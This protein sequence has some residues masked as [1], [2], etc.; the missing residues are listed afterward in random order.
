MEQ[1]K[2]LKT[3]YKFSTISLLLKFDEDEIRNCLNAIEIRNKIVHEGL[4]VKA[5]H[6]E[7]L[8]FLFQ[9][10]SK[11]IHLNGGIYQNFQE[12]I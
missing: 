7:N 4:M 12:L 9:T 1:F 8:N 10:I 2:Q 6:K 11:I 3:K 5:N